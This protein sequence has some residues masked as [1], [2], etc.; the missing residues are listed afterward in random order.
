MERLR[1]KR[2]RGVFTRPSNHQFASGKSITKSQI[3]TISSQ[4]DNKSCH[5]SQGQGDFYTPQDLFRKLQDEKVQREAFQAKNLSKK[6]FK[7]SSKQFRQHHIASHSSNPKMRQ[8]S[9]MNFRAIQVGESN[10]IS[11]RNSLDERNSSLNRLADSKSNVGSNDYR[12]H[13]RQLYLTTQDIP[14]MLNQQSTIS[15]NK[16]SSNHLIG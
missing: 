5:R 8:N 3:S 16:K 9:S 2:K 1:N 15:F 14:R 4:R 10:M 6:S 13:K 12:S 7:S 11:S